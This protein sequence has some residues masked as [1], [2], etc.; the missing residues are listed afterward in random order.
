[1][2]DSAEPVIVSGADEVVVPHVSMWSLDDGPACCDA[3]CGHAAAF[4]DV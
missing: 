4:T 3:E 1:M 2:T